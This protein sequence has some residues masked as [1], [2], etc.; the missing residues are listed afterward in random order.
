MRSLLPITILA[1]A[2]TI[3]LFAAA[4]LAPADALAAYRQQVIEQPQS[5]LGCSC[6]SCSCG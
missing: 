3:G 2:A 1:L 5:C 6:V 4:R